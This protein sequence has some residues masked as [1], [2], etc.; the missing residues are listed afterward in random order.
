[1]EAIGK[2][3]KGGTVKEKSDAP[4]AGPVRVPAPGSASAP[5]PD[6]TPSQSVPGPGD[7]KMPAKT[8]LLRSESESEYDNK[9][10]QSDS[11]ADISEIAN[12]RLAS[13]KTQTGPTTVT[14]PAKD[15]TKLPVSEPTT[16]KSSTQWV[17]LPFNSTTHLHLLQNHF[18]QTESDSDSHQ[19]Q[20]QSSPLD[21][22]PPS[23]FPWTTD[24]EE[25]SFH[26]VFIH[27]PLE[28]VSLSR[29]WTERYADGLDRMRLGSIAGYK[30]VSGTWELTEGY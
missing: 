20:I 19:S 26:N 6:K 18:Y 21:F 14:G 22:L 5:G 8:R 9:F 27:P 29:D 12:R 17:D 30:V 15:T 4:A 11:G 10:N 16:T 24:L 13:E 25:K 2:T 28:A 3:I 7:N 23:L 1:M